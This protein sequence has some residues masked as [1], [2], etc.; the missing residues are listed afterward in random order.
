M[1]KLD[2]R[3]LET[4]ERRNSKALASIAVAFWRQNQHDANNA[5]QCYTPQQLLELAIADLQNS[6]YRDIL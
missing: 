3:Q 2:K 1:E 4:Q 6:Q 5:G